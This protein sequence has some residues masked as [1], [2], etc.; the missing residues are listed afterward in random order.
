M[1]S[2]NPSKFQVELP[3][4]LIPV[5]DQLGIGQTADERVIISIAIGLYTGHVVSLARA[6]EIAGQ[7]LNQFID[8]LRQRKISW[9]NYGDEDLKDDAAFIKKL[10]GDSEPEND[11]N[12]M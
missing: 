12:R 1:M 7:S 3:S 4:E 6:A 8:V 2:L 9:A 10:L 5:L 11:E